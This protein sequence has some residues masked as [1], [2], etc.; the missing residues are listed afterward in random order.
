[1]S[2]MLVFQ[3]VLDVVGFF[4]DLSSVVSPGTLDFGFSLD[5]IHSLRSVVSLW[6]LDL[7]WRINHTYVT[8]IQSTTSQCKRRSAH[9]NSCRFYGRFRRITNRRLGLPVYILDE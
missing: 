2:A 1:M 5:F 8:N 9:F 4:K 6:T 3:D 7:G